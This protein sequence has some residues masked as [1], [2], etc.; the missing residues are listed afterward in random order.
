L[1]VHL[2]VAAAAGLWIILVSLTGSA[3]VFREEIDRAL[4]ARLYAAEAATPRARLDMIIEKIRTA[5]AG[6]ILYDLQMPNRRCNTIQVHLG[7]ARDYRRVFVEPATVH[8]LGEI[9]NRSLTSRIHDVHASL[10]LGKMGKIL[11]GLVALSLCVLCLTGVFLWWPGRLRWRDVLHLKA[12]RKGNPFRL[13][14]HRTTGICTFVLLVMWAVSGATFLFPTQFSAVMRRIT[15]TTPTPRPLSNQSQQASFSK[16]D[17]EDLIEE[18]L[19]ESADRELWSVAPPKGDQGPW[20]IVTVGTGCSP[21]GNCDH[22]NFYFDQYSGTLLARWD[23]EP[24]SPGEVLRKW[25]EGIHFGSFGG[26][27]TR[28]IWMILGLAPVVLA[29]T[30]ALIWRFGALRQRPQS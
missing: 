26:V 28:A 23:E 18:A 6:Y 7:T 21:S 17:I 20:R 1:K 24:K 14:V 5:Y 3:L 4:Y 16:P 9:T 25:L 29:V 27:G 22:R 8:I 11:N 19:E 12:W 15:H 10:L 13:D 30:G 2:W